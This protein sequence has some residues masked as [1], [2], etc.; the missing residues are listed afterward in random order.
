MVAPVLRVAAVEVGEAVVGLLGR[1]QLAGSL[2]GERDLDTAQTDV[3]VD[4]VFED[5][6]RL[7]AR[8]DEPA[9][10]QRMQGKLTCS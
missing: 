4:V 9:M 7:A 8:L 5:E 1:E 3:P 2:G 6:S 10:S